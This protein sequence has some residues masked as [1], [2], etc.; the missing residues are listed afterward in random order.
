MYEICVHSSHSVSG[1]TP[2]L[3][4]RLFQQYMVDAF[5][6]MEQTRLWWF[7]THQT[8]LRNELYTHISDSVGKG[9]ANATN[10]DFIS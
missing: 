6:T 1:M 3:G 7:R 5:S 10:V 4:G 8:I 2:R 9:D